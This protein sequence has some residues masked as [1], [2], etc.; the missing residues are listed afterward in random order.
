MINARFAKSF[1]EHWATGRE[2]GARLLAG[3]ARWTEENRTARVLGLHRQGLL[4]AALRLGRGGADDAAVPDRGVRAHGEPLHGGQLRPALAYANGTPYGLASS[5]HTEDR[6]WI[7]RFKR[8][9]HVGAVLHQR[10]QAV[11]DAPA[12]R[13]Q[14]LERQRRLGDRPAHGGGLHP[15]ARRPGQRPRAPPRPGRGK[16]R[17]LPL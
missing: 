17:S 3:G 13:R 12:L 9:S 4:H 10:R 16:R 7:E 14:R 2:D 1:E 6:D 8:E 15:L 5:L 11:P